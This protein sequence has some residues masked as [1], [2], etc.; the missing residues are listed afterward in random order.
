MRHRLSLAAFAA[1]LLAAV[2]ILLAPGAQAGPEKGTGTSGTRSQA[3]FPTAARAKPNLVII[4]ADDMGYGDIGPFGSKLNRT[5]QPRP[6][7]APKGMKLTSFYA[8]PGLHAVAGAG[9]DRLL[10]QARLAART[11]S[12]PP[13][14]SAST[15]A[16][17]TVAELLKQQGYATMCIGKWH[18]GDQPEFLP[19]RH[20]FDHYFGLPYSNDM[21]GSE[22]WPSRRKAGRPPL[23]LVRD[24]QVVETL[25]GASRTGS[26]SA[27]PT[28]R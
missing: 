8:A 14:P 23:P 28:R 19:T 3:S 18:L 11:C 10:R 7:G 12:S 25:A 27:T 6:H 21:G 5:P 16:E 1:P 2:T 22:A 26:S 20:G 9:D 17:H 13:A 15:P 24:W 4:L